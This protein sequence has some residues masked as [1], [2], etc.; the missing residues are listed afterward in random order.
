MKFYDD[1]NSLILNLTPHLIVEPV[2][3][4][5]VFFFF[6]F[7]P[8]TLYQKPVIIALAAFIAIQ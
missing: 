3:A 1:T 7:A 6:V 8:F 5:L 2:T 4:R